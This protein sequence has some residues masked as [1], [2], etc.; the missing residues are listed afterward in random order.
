[1]TRPVSPPSELT[2][3]ARQTLID[4]YGERAVM[5][6]EAAAR[7][8]PQADAGLLDRLERFSH[9]AEVA[10]KV[11]A[12]QL[13]KAIAELRTA[14]PQADA[15]YVTVL[16]SE[17]SEMFRAATDSCHKCSPDDPGFAASP[18]AP[19]GLDVERLREA[20]HR[21]QIWPPGDIAEVI[22]REYAASQPSEDGPADG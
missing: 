17:Y 14:A 5:D 19:A 15:D 4:Q 22:A 13:R 1:M 20:L 11:D 7:A 10:G 9:R 12:E 21:I 16:R 3:D 2:A 18:A 8:A 6:F